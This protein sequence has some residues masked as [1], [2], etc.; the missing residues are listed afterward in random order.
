MKKTI[1][2]LALAAQLL[3]PSVFA[4]S[5]QDSDY[6]DIAQHNIYTLQNDSSYVFQNGVSSLNSFYSS[7]QVG[8]L[9]NYA[10]ERANWTAFYQDFNDYYI[11]YSKAIAYYGVI[12][13]G[14]SIRPISDQSTRDY[15]TAQLTSDSV[16]MG[17]NIASLSSYAGSLKSYQSSALNSYYSV[18]E[19]STY[20]LIGLGA[21]GVAFV[22]RR[23]KA[24]VA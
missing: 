13:A 16:T 20:G 14:D 10:T 6:A 12:W 23:R 2:T 18:P 5:Q 3:T 8:S 22:A 19:P 24:K 15:F 4:I 9:S 7:F 17:I 1:L 21:L 11:G